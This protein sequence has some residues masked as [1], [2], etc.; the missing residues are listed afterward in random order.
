MALAR[1]RQIAR[2]TTS[3]GASSAP[4][5]SAMKRS[6]VSLMR[7]APSPRTASLTSGIGP[8]RSVERGR[9]ELHELE[10][11]EFG[12][13]ARRKRETLAETAERVGA[14]CIEPADAAGRE[15]DV[16]R[17]STSDPVGAGDDEAH[18]RFVVDDEPARLNAFEHA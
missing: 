15:D 7:M 18:D 5:V 17:A 13:G 6:P 9:M 10:V 14:V 3:R 16:S 2:A 12:A 11:G 1:C 4:G 8:R